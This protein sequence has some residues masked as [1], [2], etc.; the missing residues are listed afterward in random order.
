MHKPTVQLKLI[1][2]QVPNRASITNP[3]QNTTHTLIA[4]ANALAPGAWY[5]RFAFTLRGMAIATRVSTLPNDFICDESG[6]SYE[7]NVH[8]KAEYGEQ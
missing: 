7:L 5:Q 8:Y 3:G 4:D 1:S 6:D 2:V